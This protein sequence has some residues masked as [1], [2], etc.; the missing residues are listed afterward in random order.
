ML[1]DDIIVE[2]YAGRHPALVVVGDV[3]EGRYA[4]ALRAADGELRGGA[5]RR[6]G[7]R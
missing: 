7:G 3:A 2:R 1:L 4:I 6:A 5:R